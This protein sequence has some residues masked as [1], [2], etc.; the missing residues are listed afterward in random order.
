MPMFMMGIISTSAVLASELAKGA[1]TPPPPASVSR[2]PGTRHMNVYPVVI[3]NIMGWNFAKK[4]YLRAFKL[5]R[6]EPF[7]K[8]FDE[9]SLN[10]RH[11]ILIQ[12]ETEAVGFAK[13][14]LEHENKRDAR[15][16]LEKVST[17]VPQSDEI[18]QML[19]DLIV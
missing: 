10:M 7:K 5:F 11:R 6:G 18:R 17:I 8:N 15:K 4:E 2:K 16:V 12:L 3:S 14:C 19:D 9:W 13:N 1:I